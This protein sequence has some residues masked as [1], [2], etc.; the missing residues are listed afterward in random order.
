M[1]RVHSQA[2]QLEDYLMVQGKQPLPSRDLMSKFE[3]I[4]LF[5]AR[6]ED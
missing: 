6:A 4:A 1:A 5:L 2:K 3:R